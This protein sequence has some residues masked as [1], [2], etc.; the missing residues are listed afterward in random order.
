MIIIILL[1]V[2]MGFMALAEVQIIVFNIKISSAAILLKLLIK[3]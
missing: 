3:W 1:S 2:L